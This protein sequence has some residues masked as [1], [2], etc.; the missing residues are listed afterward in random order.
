MFL[1]LKRVPQR[2]NC[3]GPHPPRRRS[4]DRVPVLVPVLEQYIPPR[5]AQALAQALDMSPSELFTLHAHHAYA[6]AFWKE[7]HAFGA[8]IDVVDE[9]MEEQHGHQRVLGNV[10]MARIVTKQVRAGGPCRRTWS[11]WSLWRVSSAAVS[12][13]LFVG[14]RVPSS[15]PLPGGS[16]PGFV[17]V[18]W[19][20]LR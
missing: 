8:F 14:G 5:T 11:V 13:P 20:T 16:V 6:Y 18:S 12:A 17:C 1:C 7:T 9:L 2:L 19:T 3:S 4:K 10:S 15:F